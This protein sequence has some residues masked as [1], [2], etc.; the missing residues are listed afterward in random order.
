MTA[1]GAILPKGPLPVTFRDVSFGYRPGFSVLEGVSLQLAPGGV[2]GL[3]GRT[4]SGKT[5]LA[6]LLS[7]LYDPDDGA[8]LLGDTDVRETRLD[9]LRR[10]VGLV[11]QEVQVFQ[12]SVRDNLSLFDAA[13]PD[14]RIETVIGD[15]GLT[16]WYRSLPK[17][18]DTELA[19]GASGLSA[20]EAQLLAFARVFLRDPSVVVLDEASSRLDPHT[21]G[22]IDRA[23][24][25]M[26]QGR[27][28][29]VIAHRVTTVDRADEIA[30]LDRGRVVEHGGR[31]ALLSDPSS[32]FSQLWRSGLGEV[33]A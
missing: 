24:D 8:I 20:G 27:T 33:L 25:R 23:L 28:A 4:G 15:V 31:A 17:G 18:L 21:E 6:R 29:I 14:D 11:T 1:R 12:A 16:R 5:T 7:R 13:I 26:L 2:L 30:L 22:L 9:D 10:R 3:L 19:S 32:R